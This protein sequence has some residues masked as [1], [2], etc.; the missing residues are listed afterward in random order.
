[1]RPSKKEELLEK[2]LKVFYQHGF[3][4]TG[5]DFIAKQTGI[6]KTLIYSHFSNKDALMSAVLER[7]DTNFRQWLE[8]RVEAL[9][10]DPLSKL[11][12]VF[13]ALEEWFDEEGFKGCMFVKASSEFMEPSHP[14]Y[15]QSAAH[16]QKLELYFSQLA[17]E[18]GLANHADIA[19]HIVLLKEGAIN[20][21]H[22]RMFPKPAQH[23]KQ[24]LEQL[25]GVKAS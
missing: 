10:T 22:L 16:K 17:K 23:A 5:V 25:I 3:H 2:S 18:A 6:S 14:L 7:R 21:A 4:A 1:M 12:C 19:K 15:Q 11:F 20:A 9:S 24:M 13:D 8:A